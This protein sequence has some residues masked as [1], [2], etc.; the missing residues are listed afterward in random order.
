MVRVRE[1]IKK[2]EKG[3]EIYTMN[4]KEG[5]VFGKQNVELI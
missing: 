2:L 1:V 5:K 4:M 3:F